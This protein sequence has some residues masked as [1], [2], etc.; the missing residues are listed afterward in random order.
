MLNKLINWEYC[1]VPVH[2]KILAGKLHCFALGLQT[3]SACT[4]TRQRVMHISSDICIL[5]LWVGEMWQ[6]RQK[7]LHD[8]KEN[9]SSDVCQNETKV[10]RA[11]AH[12]RGLISECSRGVN[13][14]GCGPELRRGT[15]QTSKTHFLQCK[16][17]SSEVSRQLRLLRYQAKLHHDCLLNTRWITSWLAQIC[18]CNHFIYN[19]TWN[20]HF[21]HLWILSPLRAAAALRSWAT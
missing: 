5:A 19:Q 20:S 21:L 12:Q 2:A 10:A 4:H 9:M 18:T 8:W 11:S 6:Q 16:R 14:R 13:A 3:S 7:H 1:L 15:I 17:V